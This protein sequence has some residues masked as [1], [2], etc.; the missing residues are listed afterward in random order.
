MALVGIP[1]ETSAEMGSTLA[2]VLTCIARYITIYWADGSKTRVWSPLDEQAVCST[3]YKLFTHLKDHEDEDFS[4]DDE[5]S[6]SLEKATKVT[7]HLYSDIVTEEDKNHFTI[8]LAP[9]DCGSFPSENTYQC[10][11]QMLQGQIKLFNARD[12]NIHMGGGWTHR[13]RICVCPAVEKGAEEN[14]DA[15]TLKE[16]I[17]WGK[18][19]A[20]DG[21]LT[22]FRL[23]LAH[24]D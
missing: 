12:P 19:L 17:R 1:L 5:L 3:D 13:Y 4:Q 8:V 11:D 21:R 22:R 23:V 9:D 18:Q 7:I 24:D 20:I 10:F 15:D 16:L 2:E 6:L 14:I